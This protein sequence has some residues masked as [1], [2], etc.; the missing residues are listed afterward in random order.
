M[1]M[2]NPDYFTEMQ[3]IAP[4]L[5]DYQ[6]ERI[7]D[8]I[9]DF[10]RTN[11][12]CDTHA[13]EYCPKCGVQSPLTTKGGRAG[14]GKPMLR[15][16]ACG[17]RFVYDTGSLTY[18]SHQPL[19][20]WTRFIEMTIDKESI[21]KCAEEIEVSTQTAFRMRHKLM[22]FN[23]MMRADETIGGLVELDETYIHANK[24]G[25]VTKELGEKHFLMFCLKEALKG[26]AG[27]EK[28]RIEARINALEKEIQEMNRMQRKA[29]RKEVK[30]GISRQLVCIFTGI[31]RG[32]RS[33]GMASSLG[34]PTQ[35]ETAA[36]VGHIEQGSHVW[37]DGMGSYKPS[38]EANGCTHTECVKG[39][40]T[41]LDHVN[42]INAMHSDFKGWI[43]KYR[44]V[45]TVYADRY[46]SLISYA[47][48]HRGNV[49]EEKRTSMLCDL[50]KR[51]LYFYV[52]D[53]TET[54]I[55]RIDDD[56]LKRNG[57]TTV[58]DE[59]RRAMRNP[60]TPEEIK[61]VIYN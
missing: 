25:L 49:V 45:N 26:A 28:E 1:A 39:E 11:A 14:S 54:D 22:A 51:Q 37:T 8:M 33:L 57:M 27:E 10:L 32:G 56:Q 48:D 36:F 31:E 3:E 55:L 61:A 5:Q 17:R 34:R 47:Y 29:R 58:M 44:G 46:A 18:Y 20:K 23:R 4:L 41:A 13:I 38:L 19:A 53:I 43:R 35:R 7:N 24:K 16:C 9:A 40:Y 50:N 12:E 60:M 6:I 2:F 42:N 59:W 15:C 30:R 21:A 52:R